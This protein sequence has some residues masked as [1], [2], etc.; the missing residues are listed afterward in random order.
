MRLKGRLNSLVKYFAFLFLSAC[1]GG[2]DQNFFSMLAVKERFDPR[3]T[4]T[5]RT[6]GIEKI[7]LLWIVDNS[8]SMSDEQAS[9]SQNFHDFAQ[10]YLARGWDFRTSVITSDA[11]LARQTGN[12]NYGANNAENYAKLLP[13]IHDGVRPPVNSG[14]RSGLPVLDTISNLSLQQLVDAFV[15]NA[16]PGITG[17]GSERGLESTIKFLNNNEIE[18]NCSS[19]NPAANCFFRK[20]SARIFAFVTDE[21]DSSYKNL[22]PGVEPG[23][24]CNRLAVRTDFLQ[25]VKTQWDNYLRDLNSF[26]NLDPRYYTISI[27]N[28]TAL[29]GNEQYHGK[30]LK[31]FTELVKADNT[32]TL[33]KYSTTSNING[34]FSTILDEIGAQLQQVVQS[35]VS[36]NEFNLTR[37]P[38]GIDDMNMIIVFDNGSQITVPKTEYTVIGRLVSINSSYL[39]SMSALY[40]VIRDVFIEYTPL[41]AGQS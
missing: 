1:G 30:E 11:Y 15:I 21:C 32:N 39:D 34:N 31:A 5:V 8:G 19:D 20:N 25:N 10:T 3:S 23:L 27:I 22:R 7:D 29:G 13:G 26:G 24:D 35:Q 36:V 40:G 14:V 17:S 28:Q 38:T 41:H 16:K 6:S 2:T 18:D 33:G 12:A 9:L 37:D 4:L